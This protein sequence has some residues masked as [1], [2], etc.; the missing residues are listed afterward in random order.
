MYDTIRNHLAQTAQTESFV[1]LLAVE[2]GSHAWGFP[3]ADS[4]RDIR[5]VYVRPD[6]AY[7]SLTPP[8][9]SFESVCTPNCDI[10]GWDIFKTLSLLRKS[11][12][13]L[14]EWLQSPLVYQCDDDFTA[15]MRRLMPQCFQAAPVF[16]HYRD[17]AHN[18][19]STLELHGEIRLKRWFYAL[20]PLLAARWTARHGLPPVGLNE[21]AAELSADERAQLTEL[22]EFKARHPETCRCHL[23]VGL[24]RLSRSLYDETLTLRPPPDLP[25]PET[26][27][28]DELLYHTVKRFSL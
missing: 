21:L 5:T 12:A 19:L 2:S 9:D 25:P 4:G 8:R 6:R 22:A 13:V 11:N 14:L 17:I 27:V 15:E 26:A 7:L 18:A 10:G 20:R 1:L 24:I 23:P 28:L 3:S 16:H